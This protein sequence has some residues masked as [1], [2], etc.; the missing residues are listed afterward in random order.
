MKQSERIQKLITLLKNS[1]WDSHEAL[2]GALEKLG[3]SS[4]QATL[5]RDLNRLGVQKVHGIYQ[6]PGIDS[7]IEILPAGANLLVVKT[8]PGRASA[9]AAEVDAMML[10]GLVGTIAGDDTIFIA[11][12]DL[13]SQNQIQKGLL[14]KL[15]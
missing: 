5:S 10:P 6:L 1:R 13:K 3:I 8:L 15:V 14:E 11:T 12:T 4:T 7:S 9:I 2:L